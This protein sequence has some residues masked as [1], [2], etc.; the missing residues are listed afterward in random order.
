M[1]PAWKRALVAAAILALATTACAMDSDAGEIP[2]APTTP[3]DPLDGTGWQL[4]QAESL[5]IPADLVITVAFANRSITG[6]GG[7]NRYSGTYEV[8]GDDLTIELSASTTMACVP[9][10]DAAEQVFL[11]AL[12]D[13]E[14]FDQP[15][16]DRLVLTTSNDARLTFGP[17]ALDVAGSWEA[18]GYR[19]AVRTGFVSVL[20]GTELTATFDRDGTVSGSTGCNEYSGSYTVTDSNITIGPLEATERA[21]TEPDGVMEQ[22]AGYLNALQSAETFRLDAGTLVLLDNENADAVRFSP[23]EPIDPTG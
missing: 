10:V 16:E 17:Q 5:E 18:T 2:T 12:A 13:V 11:A 14:S 9:R 4:E 7:C 6:S 20:A 1:R 8:D 19:N 3:P 23:T 21:C 15:S 22:E